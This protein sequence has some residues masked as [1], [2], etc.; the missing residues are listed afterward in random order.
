[1]SGVAEDPHPSER[2]VMNVLTD[3]LFALLLSDLEWGQ[4]W[5]MR[6]EYPHTCIQVP[7]SASMH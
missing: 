4:V 2:C 7:D 6:E 5:R 3:A 1:M